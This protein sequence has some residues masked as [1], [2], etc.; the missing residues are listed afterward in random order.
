MRPR[1]DAD[2]QRKMIRCLSLLACI[3]ALTRPASPCFAE[4]ERHTGTLEEAVVAI[5][6]TNAPA[7]GAPAAPRRGVGFV[8]RC[9]GFILAPAGLFAETRSPGPDTTESQAVTVVLYPGSN[10]EKR[11]TGLP[12]P[13]YFA[14]QN[15]GFVAFKLD[16]VDVPALRTRLLDSGHPPTQVNLVWRA[17]DAV[18]GK[19]GPLMRRNG[20]IDGSPSLSGGIRSPGGVVRLRV[21]LSDVPPGAVVLSPDGMAVGM[22]T[23]E[24]TGSAASFLSF[25]QL[26]LVT[27]CVTPVP[28]ADEEFRIAERSLPVEERMVAVPGGRVALPAALLREQ[29]DLNGEKTACIA[30]FH[31]DRCEVTNGEYLEFWNTLAERE[32]NDPALKSACYPLSWADASPPFPAAL[33]NRPVLGVSLEGARVYARFRGKRLPTPYEW[34]FAALGPDGETAVPDWVKRYLADR[35]SAWESVRDQHVEYALRHAEMLIRDGFEPSAS[36]SSQRSRISTEIPWITRGEEAREAALFSRR[37]VESATARLNAARN[38][39]NTIQD[40]G[41][42]MFDVSPSGARDMILNAAELVAPSPSPPASG[43]IRFLRIDWLL[44]RAMRPWSLLISDDFVPPLSGSLLSELTDRSLNRLIA[45]TYEESKRGGFI[46]SN[47]TQTLANLCE[48][49]ALLAP[50]SGWTVRVGSAMEVRSALRPTML[51]VV[52]RYLSTGALLWSYQRDGFGVWQAM[53]RDLAMETGRT[54]SLHPLDLPMPARS[55]DEFVRPDSALLTYLV[56]VGFRC[57]R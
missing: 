29:P 53:P 40:R 18:T 35:R 6:V 48:Q 57:A 54:I 21:P 4:D 43:K 1:I 28:T 32:R 39:P 12:R 55:P 46:L 17:W 10:R 37:T 19:N 5:E 22:V 15:T 24:S 2:M 26:H 20:E 23:G 7:K 41:S 56:P 42:R 36:G 50:L 30:P 33:A 38:M 16:G 27:N 11:I 31:I 47:L 52:N 3:C 49:I 14:W 8:L 44:D 13:H 25:E 34:V 45:A 9:D 51:Q